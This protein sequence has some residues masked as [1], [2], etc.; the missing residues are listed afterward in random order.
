[1][2]KNSTTLQDNKIDSIALGGFDGLHIAHQKLVSHLDKHGAL[3]VIKKNI[4]ILTPLGYRKH[5]LDKPILYAELQEIKHLN[6][7]E[8]IE[9]LMKTYPNLQKIVIGY[10]F[11]FG[12]GRSCGIEELEKFFS[13]EVVVVPE[14]IVDEISVHS[15][16]IKDFI[17]D[18]NIQ[19][20]NKLLGRQYQIQGKIIKG[21]GLG[22]K[23][24]V[25][26]VN[27]Y[28]D[29]F[30][31]PN[32]GVYATKTKVN[33]K[34]YPSVTFIGHRDTTDGSF[35]VETHIINETIEA[36]DEAIVFFV[37]KIR[38]NMKFDSLE[39]LKEQI[40]EDIKLTLRYI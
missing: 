38:E 14:V 30:L 24:L 6:C 26:T 25:P 23:K 13:G 29:K 32:E 37:D 40:E 16:K 28:I 19:M 21:Q 11:R 39:K 18:G 20:A 27:L 12:K 3:F 4:P 7:Q 2:L 36:K 33:N 5:F 9:L 10:D 8:F 31:L 35:A 34:L 22:A 17:R 15:Y 1:M